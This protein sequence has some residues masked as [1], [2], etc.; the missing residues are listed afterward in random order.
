MRT[1]ENGCN[2]SYVRTERLAHH[3]SNRSWSNLKWWTFQTQRHP[4]GRSA[5][6]RRVSVPGVPAVRTLIRALAHVMN[7]STQPFSRNCLQRRAR[8]LDHGK[9]FEHDNFLRVFKP[10]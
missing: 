9:Y 10:D 1:F 7:A 8:Q 4:T 6:A 3:R 5:F 2:V